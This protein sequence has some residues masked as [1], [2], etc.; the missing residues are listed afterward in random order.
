M[1]H[2][3]III[4]F[5]YKKNLCIGKLDRIMLKESVVLTSSVFLAAHF[6][7]QPSIRTFHW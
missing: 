3:N 1:K 4:L 2:P 6:D 5:V 7:L